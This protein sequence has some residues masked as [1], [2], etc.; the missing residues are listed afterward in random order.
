MDPRPFRFGTYIPRFGSAGEL[1]ELAHKVEALGYGALAGGDHAAFAVGSPLVALGAVA[2]A[3]STLRLTAHV[4]NN[5]LR[6]PALLA[7]ELAALDTLSDGRLEIGLGAGWLR[8]DYDALGLRFDLAAVRVARLAEAVQILKRLWTGEPTTYAGEHYQIRGLALEQLRPAQPRPPIFIGGGGPRILALAA[9][10]ADI[11]GIDP[12]GTPGGA[13]DDATATD[14]AFA[15]KITRVRRLAGE[16]A[17]A[18]ELHTF[19]QAVQITDDR[20]RV[21]EDVAAEW[22]GYPEDIVINADWDADRV[23]ASPHALIGS[24]DQVC[25]LLE[26]RRERYGVSYI[27]VGPGSIDAFAPVVARL[28]GT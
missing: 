24:V 5:D 9:R 23:L 17:A 19:V 28:A 21:A 25:A 4:L 12:K 27:S 7:G 3:T 2:A 14:D 8:R 11:I 10:E 22:R 18:I 13:K 6:H 1:R 26:E 15:D 16:R 20:Q